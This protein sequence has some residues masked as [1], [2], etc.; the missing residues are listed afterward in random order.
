MNYN[1]L[2][3]EIEALKKLDHNNIIKLYTYFQLDNNDELALVLEYAEGGTLKEFLNSKKILNE[4]QTRKIVIQIL[5]ALIYC[6]GKKIIHRDLKLENVMYGDKEMNNL[7]VIDFG[8]AGLFQKDNFSAG[9]VRY[10]PPEVLSGA[11]CDS[12]PSIDCWALGCIIYELLTGEKLFKGNNY[13]EIK[14]PSLK[15][16]YINFN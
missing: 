1:Y 11:N 7:K 5:D 3:K 14:V 15:Y 6:H 8:I 4:E 13:K 9:T 12:L 10:L 2:Y 16:I